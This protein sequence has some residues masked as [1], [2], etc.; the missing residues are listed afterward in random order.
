MPA[1]G[2][3]A[4]LRSAAAILDLDCAD[5]EDVHRDQ[6]EAGGVDHH[7]RVDVG[8]RPLTR[9]ADLAATALFS[10]CAENDDA[11]ARFA[12]D[13]CQRDAGAGA[14]PQR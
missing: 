5:G 4:A 10:R 8:E 14:R 1:C 7:R 9:H 13:R 2:A 6:I 11:A 12:E 3:A